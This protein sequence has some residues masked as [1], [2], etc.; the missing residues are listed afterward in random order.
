MINKKL[1]EITIEDLKRLVDDNVIEKKTLEYKLQL[2]NDSNSSKKEFLADVSSLANTLGGDLIFGIGEKDGNPDNVKGFKLENLDLEISR[3]E[4]II[5]DGISPRINI[6]LRVIDI[7]ESKKVIILRTKASLDI[8]HRVVFSGHDKFYRRNSNGKYPMDI[9]ELKTTFLQTSSLSEK[10]KNFRKLR[11][12]DIK[13]GETPFPVSDNSSFMA[14]HILPLSAFNTSFVLNSTTLLALKEGRYSKLFS[15]FY[16]GSWSHRINL[17]GVV[18]YSLI[19]ESKEVGTYTQFFRSGK[20]EAVESGILSRMKEADKKILPI[21]AIENNVMKYSEKTLRL[22]TELEFQPPF[23][24]FLSLT[25]IKGSTISTPEE[26]WPLETELITIDDLML[27]EIVI[28]DVSDNI[29][30][31]FRPIFDIIWNAAGISKSL[32]F[33]DDNNFIIKP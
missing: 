28:E 25:G 14:I 6:D 9:N 2:P 22:L 31:K 17:D 1:S 32:N 24:I 23:Y 15:P 19:R 4:N 20:I 21:G 11:I 8:P 27:P 26:M 18:A 16:S 3:L 5:R 10:I 13:S 30:H 33:D 12:L 7:E 29:Q